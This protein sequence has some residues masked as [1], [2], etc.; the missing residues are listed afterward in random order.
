MIVEDNPDSRR[1]LETLLRLEG[2]EVRSASDGE[3]GL[4][5]ILEVRPDLA[6]VDIGLPGLSGYDV[7]RKM[8]ASFDGRLS[9]P[10][11]AHRIRPRRRPSPCDRGRLRCAP[12]QA[13]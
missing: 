12:R 9:P 4:A 11:R 13:H 8:R 6:L 5:A 7:A 1:M 3:E 10:G 2:C